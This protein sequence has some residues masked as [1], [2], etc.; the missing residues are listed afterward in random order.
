MPRQP[1]NKTSQE[2]IAAQRT[3]VPIVATFAYPE[4][5]AIGTAFIIYTEGKKA[6]ALTAAH[7]FEAIA[8][9]DRPYETYHPTMPQEFRPVV[10]SINF[11]DA[12]PRV[13][14]PG[15]DDGRM[16]TVRITG[17]YVLIPADI[18][19]VTLSIP[20]TL[21]D[22]FVFSE[23]LSIDSSPP[24]A[25]TPIRLAGY[26]NMSVNPH[27]DEIGTGARFTGRF[28]PRDG[29]IIEVFRTLGPRNKPWPCFQ[30]NT[31]ID[32]GMSGSP[33]LDISGSH[34]VVAVGIAS[35]DSSLDPSFAASG[36]DAF[37]AI[38]WP[39]MTI[40]LEQ[41]NLGGMNGPTLMELARQGL[42]ADRGKAHE[43][44]QVHPDTTS[45]RVLMRWV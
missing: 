28:D 32:S 30:C 39:A 11:R 2:L 20:N 6:I 27:Q 5:E 13:L 35:S 23:R 36:A 16:Y 41:E 19:V 38:I 40:R 45:E 8:R 12:T 29:E 15:L 42:I 25:G 34:D 10:R 4:F 26:W 21:P 43:H 9:L 1:S 17:A 37:A 7:N 33:L 14:Y 44:I 3:I 31:P 24:R 22:D 18:A